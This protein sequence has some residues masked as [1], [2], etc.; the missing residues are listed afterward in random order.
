M[1][2]ESAFLFSVHVEVLAL[3][4][5]YGSNSGIYEWLSLSIFTIRQ[6]I[7]LKSCLIILFSDTNTHTVQTLTSRP[8]NFQSQAAPSSPT[9]KQNKDNTVGFSQLLFTVGHVA[10]KQIVHLELCELDFKRRKQEKER[11][12]AAAKGPPTSPPLPL[13]QL[14]ANLPKLLPP[15]THPLVL[16]NRKRIPIHLL[17]IHHHLLPKHHFARPQYT[18][19]SLAAAREQ[20]LGHQPPATVPC[21]VRVVVN[22]HPEPGAAPEERIPFWLFH[23]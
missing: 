2:D 12:V 5:G 14:L 9:K 21:L 19:P 20:H 3:P 4:G 16:P 13:L 7:R 8:Y 17:H 11:T 1:E 15:P 18:C 10:I 22:P 23:C 6:H